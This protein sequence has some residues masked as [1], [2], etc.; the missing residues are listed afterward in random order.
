MYVKNGET[1]YTMENLLA[2]PLT[3]NY[4]LECIKI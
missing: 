3:G 2:H 1:V 4:Y